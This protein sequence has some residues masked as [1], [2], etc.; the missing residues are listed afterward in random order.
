MVD[1]YDLAKEKLEHLL[2]VPG[3]MPVPLFQL[4]PALESLRDRPRFKK[5]TEP[6]K[7]SSI[8]NN[9]KKNWSKQKLWMSDISDAKP[10][11]M[12]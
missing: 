1:E 9:D 6:D 10:T 5:L 12:S 7:W 8:P 2:S 4:D 3:E 11:F